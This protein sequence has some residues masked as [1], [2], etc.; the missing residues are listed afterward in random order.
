MLPF[1]IMNQYGNQ[2]IITNIKDIRV[3]Q[4]NS[5]LV[6]MQD[7]RLYGFG[8]NAQGELGQGNQSAYPNFVL[9]DTGVDAIWG[10]VASCM[11]RKD[12]VYYASGLVTFVGSA[13]ITY[14]TYTN[15]NSIFG[16][17][18]LNNIKKIDIDNSMYVLMNDGS[19]YGCGG[20]A[21]GQLGTGNTIRVNS[22]TKIQTDVTDFKIFPE[23][24]VFILKGTELYSAGNNLNGQLGCSADFVN[25]TSFTKVTKFSTVT[26]LDNLSGTNRA[27]YYNNNGTVYASGSPDY[28]RFGDNSTTS[29]ITLFSKVLT[30][31]PSTFNG[32]I[33]MTKCNQGSCIF[34]GTDGLYAAGTNIYGFGNPLRAITTFSKMSTIDIID[35]S[36]INL[37]IGTNKGTYYAIDNVLY[38]TGAA[39]NV[40]GYINGSNV[41]VKSGTP[42]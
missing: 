22:I 19:L 42:T 18:D 31:L 37:L 9:I 23:N 11:Y 36:K 35:Y 12:G 8:D 30:T 14:T 34:G 17:L 2:I 25:I 41:F 39:N 24:R 28:Y 16:S 40:P 3:S 26:N 1:P 20:N 32:K 4:L 6:L 13:N 27:T 33:F 21:N 29:N 15:V 38:S 5:V 7:G 10:G